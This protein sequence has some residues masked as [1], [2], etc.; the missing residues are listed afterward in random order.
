M[1][2]TMAIILDH[3]SDLLSHLSRK[4][5]SLI[6]LREMGHGCCVQVFN[7]IA[8]GGGGG[9]N[10]PLIQHIIPNVSCDYILTAICSLDK[11]NY[12]K[13]TIARCSFGKYT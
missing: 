10:R 13:H 4:G 5:L 11:Q 3:I 2:P 6:V 8:G 9:S 7:I 1:D 12:C